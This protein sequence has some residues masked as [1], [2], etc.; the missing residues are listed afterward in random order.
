MSVAFAL[1]YA[2]YPRVCSRA[3]DKSRICRSLKVEGGD[4]GAQ[5]LTPPADVRITNVAL[6]AELADQKGRTSVKLVYLP[7]GDSDDEDEEEEEEGDEEAQASRGAPTETILC[8]LIP[9]QVCN[10]SCF[11]ERL[12]HPRN[13][14]LS[15]S[16]STL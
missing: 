1:W 16:T 14:R 8:T 6:G 7:F 11:S 2:A 13:P 9:G 15:R 5:E 12:P 10:A 3:A 4:D